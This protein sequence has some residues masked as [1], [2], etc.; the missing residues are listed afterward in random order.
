M[1][2]YVINMDYVLV[3]QNIEIS[4]Q[5]QLIALCKKPELVKNTSSD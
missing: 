4:T 2:N 5:V 1:E 3:I